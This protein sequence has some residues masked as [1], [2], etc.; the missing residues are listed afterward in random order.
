MKRIIALLITALLCLSALAA[1]APDA[2]PPTLENSSRQSSQS[3][4]ELKD[5]PKITTDEEYATDEEKLI[6]GFF[7]S[8]YSYCATL[9]MQNFDEYLAD[10]DDN[11][12]LISALKYGAAVIKNKTADGVHLNFENMTCT[13]NS[14][15]KTYTFN[16]VESYSYGGSS[17]NTYAAEVDPEEMKIVKV[18]GT[19]KDSLPVWLDS[20]EAKV[21]EF[22]TRYGEE[23]SIEEVTELIIADELAADC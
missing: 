16:I 3:G 18:Y 12:M 9:E 7:V 14:G 8:Y 15:I 19:A 6:Y 2:E 17:S 21:E 22:R 13:E 20:F 1:C 10:N 5:T 11:R 4:A 23:L